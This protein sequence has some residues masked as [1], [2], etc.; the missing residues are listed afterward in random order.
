MP[1]GTPS[2]AGNRFADDNSRTVSFK[3]LAVGQRI[4]WYNVKDNET[5]DAVIVRIVSIHRKSGTSVCIAKTEEGTQFL[6]DN[7]NVKDI[8]LIP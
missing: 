5:I 4:R 1:A 7:T 3:K 2:G 8:E 6:I